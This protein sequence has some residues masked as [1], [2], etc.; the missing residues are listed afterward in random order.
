M[1]GGSDD[2]VAGKHTRRSALHLALNLR[3]PLLTSQLI[4][5]TLTLPPFAILLALICHNART[6]T[7]FLWCHVLSV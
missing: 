4:T 2:E 7:R 1:Q 6:V 5:C 3:L